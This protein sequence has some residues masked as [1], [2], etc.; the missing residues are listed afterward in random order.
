MK[1]DRVYVLHIVDC[2][3]RIQRYCETEAF[4]TSDLVQDAVLRNLQVL[5][6]ST[7]RISAELKLLHP[8]VDWRAIAGF[9]NVLVHDYLGDHSG[10]CAG[11]RLRSVAEA[12]LAN[13]SD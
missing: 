9:R 4:T 3:R 6:E 12:A 2:V 1:D 13:G 5:A 10:T 7:Q 11:N 8:E